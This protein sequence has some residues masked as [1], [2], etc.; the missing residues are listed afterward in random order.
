[1]LLL[2][3][4]VCLLISFHPQNFVPITE[5]PKL[6]GTSFQLATKNSHSL[7]EQF[8]F[9]PLGLIENRMARHLD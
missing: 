9:K 2:L 4:P 7:Y 6:I 5:H 1:M 8:S 3:S